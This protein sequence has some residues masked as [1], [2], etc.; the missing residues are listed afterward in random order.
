MVFIL[1]IHAVE[2]WFI[3][4]KELRVGKIDKVSADFPFCILWEAGDEKFNR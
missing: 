1:C 3:K 4:V 2:I